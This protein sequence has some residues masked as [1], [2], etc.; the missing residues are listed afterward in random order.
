MKRYK[1]NEI[2]ASVQGEGPEIGHRAVFI[3][4]SGCNLNC[5]FCDT[6]HDVGKDMTRGEILDAVMASSTAR[7]TAKFKY[8]VT[9]GE[10]LLQVDNELVRFLKSNL[11][12]SVANRAQF[13]LETNGLLPDDKAQVQAA[14]GAV[15]SSFDTV[16]ISPKTDEILEKSNR[17]MLAAATSIKVLYP[18]P[19]GLTF[20][21]VIQIVKVLNVCAQS[22]A[23]FIIQPVTPA[24]GLGVNNMDMYQQ[25]C[26]DSVHFADRLTAAGGANWLVIPQ[27]HVMM[28]IQ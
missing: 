8:V 5:S 21:G 22:P 17:E 3:R 13:S 7:H 10:P 11:S 15:T 2:F 28:G 19:E 20:D 4:F 25:V 18:L 26:R 1:I 9:G 16:V 6:K 12:A 23:V 27:T 14:L 24:G